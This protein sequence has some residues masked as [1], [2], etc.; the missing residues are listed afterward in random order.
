MRAFD[1]KI[2]I[3]R[4]IVEAFVADPLN[5]YAP[6]H[7]SFWLEAKT[8]DSRRNA[9]KFL[10][11]LAISMQKLAGVNMN[12][13]RPASHELV[14]TKRKMLKTADVSAERMAIAMREEGRR[15]AKLPDMRPT[16]EGG[17]PSSISET[18]P[19]SE[20]KLLFDYLNEVIIPTVNDTIE[21]DPLD[22]DVTL[23]TQ[24]KLNLRLFLSD[25]RIRQTGCKQL[26]RND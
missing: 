13:K 1:I 3:A 23:V 16:T 21:D 8:E 11:T 14:S 17:F 19:S 12:L 15:T 22:Q 4:G 20:Q 9:F 10:C 5:P 25:V 7:E 24:F 2:E 18:V 26:I 6:R